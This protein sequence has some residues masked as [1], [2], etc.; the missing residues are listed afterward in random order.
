MLEKLKVIVALICMLSYASAETVS[1]GAVRTRGE[2]RV[3]GYRVNGNATLF[4]GSVVETDQATADLQLNKGTEIRLATNSRGT[5]YR[6]HLVLQQGSSELS[7]SSA[8]QLEAKGL[9]VK[10]SEPNSRGVVSLRSN[11]TIEVAAL[12][13][14][15]GI[16]NS[17]GVLVASVRPGRS[18]ALASMDATN[19]PH[20]E[21]FSA[22]GIVSYENGHYYLTTIEDV[23]VELVGQNL[24]NFVGSKV[25]VTGTTQTS[26]TGQ[27]S[28]N[29]V[30]NVSKIQINGG[31]G[32]GGSSVGKISLGTKV[33]ISSVVVAAGVGTAVGVYEAN[34]STTSASR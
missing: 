32:S 11:N 12:S 30:V 5:L 28:A 1:I 26:S 25:V 33:I 2:M 22:S 4:D 29:L 8:F 15:F 31:S 34:Q 14:S 16:T 6:D 7:S 9:H 18:L 20:L 23:K 19:P 3:D 24:K 13:G 21:S 17:R 10:A 27:Q